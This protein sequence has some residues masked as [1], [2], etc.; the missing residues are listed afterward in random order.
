MFSSLQVPIA[1]VKTMCTLLEVALTYPGSP[2]LVGEIQKLQPLLAMTFVF[3]FLWGLAGNVTG[4]K[5]GEVD[6][7]I[8]N[9]FDECSEARVSRFALKSTC[10]KLYMTP[11]LSF[12]DAR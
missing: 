11:P 7:L 1:R 6:S 9:L 4:D 12:L 10:E 5:A 2:E 3:A 8:R